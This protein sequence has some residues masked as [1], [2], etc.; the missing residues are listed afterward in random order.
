MHNLQFWNFTYPNYPNSMRAYYFTSAIFTAWIDW[1]LRV[2]E[3]NWVH[4]IK[5][6]CQNIFFTS[7]NFKA[8][9]TF[10]YAY[11]IFRQCIFSKKKKYL[12]FF[13]TSDLE[14]SFEHNLE[15]HFFS[16]SIISC[17]LRLVYPNYPNSMRAYYFTPTI[18][19]AWIIW[20]LR[21]F[22]YFF[23]IKVKSAQNGIKH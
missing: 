5:L 22:I 8:F 18:F 20:F 9:I 23:Q 10:P 21:V 14:N 17:S 3:I 2:R 6:K 15:L 16:L 7:Q 4:F 1:F 12:Y 19:T 13:R 11:C